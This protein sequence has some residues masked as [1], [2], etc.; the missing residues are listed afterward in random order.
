M[1]DYTRAPLAPEQ[2]SPAAT[3]KV[4]EEFFRVLREFHTVTH[5]AGDAKTTVDILKGILSEAE[6]KSVV[7]AG[8]PTA[9]K[10]LVETAL[11]GVKHSFV[12]DLKAS[13]A[14]GVISKADVGVTWASYGAARQGC[15]IEVAYDDAIK[16]ASSL[17]RVHVALL[18]SRD[19]LPELPLAVAKVA[20]LLRDEGAK[21][22]VISI[23]SGPSKTADIE[24]RL[25]YGVHGPHALHVVVLDW[26]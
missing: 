12:E 1:Q 16:L 18:S 10:M 25:V 26:L 20:A 24:M 9:A 6:P 3:P 17:P 14:V 11:K 23:I 22:P 15:I 5:L 21:K 13:E 19:V 4:I 2:G 8:L 7:A